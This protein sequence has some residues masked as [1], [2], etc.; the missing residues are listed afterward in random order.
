M[1][2]R[3]SQR[4][5]M[6]S[7]MVTGV[8]RAITYPMVLALDTAGLALRNAARITLFFDVFQACGVIRKFVH[9]IAH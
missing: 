9:K 7:A 4:V 5:D 6:P 2:D 8:G 1:K 3:A